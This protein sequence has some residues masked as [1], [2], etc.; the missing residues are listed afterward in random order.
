MTGLVKLLA[1][2]VDCSGKITIAGIEEQAVTTSTILVTRVILVVVEA[3]RSRL[4][5]YYWY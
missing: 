4:Q 2:L 3:S 5:S 1:T